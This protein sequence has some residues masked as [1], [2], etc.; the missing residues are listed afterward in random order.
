MIIFSGVLKP[1]LLHAEAYMVVSLSGG[2]PSTDPKIPPSLLPG[3]Y[4]PIY[5]RF[6]K[7][8]RTAMFVIA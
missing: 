3:P 6:Y 7:E 1:A 8:L 2:T 4:T 5:H